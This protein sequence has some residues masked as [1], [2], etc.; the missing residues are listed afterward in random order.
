LKRPRVTAGF[1]ASTLT[2]CVNV[3]GR[4]VRAVKVCGV[5]NVDDAVLVGE[6]SLR[7][8]TSDVEVFL[9][10]IVWPGSR[11]SVSLETCANITKAARSYGMRPVGVF[12]DESVSDITK[13]CKQVGIDIIQL[14]GP[15]CRLDAIK[16]PIPTAAPVAA[17]RRNITRQCSRSYGEVQADG[18]R[19]VFW[20]DRGRQSA[21]RR[22][23]SEAINARILAS[24]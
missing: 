20:C 17:C 18:D 21:K 16:T 12:V 6:L 8:L 4:P 2:G 22:G 13:I 3:S 15:K 10:M 19:R 23:E 7:E 9:G 11:R 5:A 14:H 1:A 24:W